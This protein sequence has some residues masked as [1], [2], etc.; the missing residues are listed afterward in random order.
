M[1]VFLRIPDGNPFPIEV[2]ND[3]TVGNLH[4][5]ASVELGQDINLS[6]DRQELDENDDTKLADVG[7]GAEAHLDVQFVLMEDWERLSETFKPLLDDRVH[8]EWFQEC[9]TSPDRCT[10]EAICAEGSRWTK[11]G[12]IQC[13]EANE[14]VSIWPATVTMFLS[15]HLKLIRIPRTVTQMAF[16]FGRIKSVSFVGIAK[17]KDLKKLIL[18]H[19]EI[20]SVDFRGLE[21]S[22]LEDLNLNDN[23]IASFDNLHALKHSALTQLLLDENKITAFNLGVLQNS[24]LTYLSLNSNQISAVDLDL[25]DSLLE[26]LLLEHNQITSIDL[27]KLKK[28]QLRDLRLFDNRISGTMNFGDLGGSKLLSIELRRNQIKRISFVSTEL[29]PLTSVSANDNSIE[30]IDF[31]G[32]SNFPE[33]L[34]MEW[35][36]SNFGGDIRLENE[37]EMHKMGTLEGDGI[38]RNRK[39][40]F[41]KSQYRYTRP[42]PPSSNSNFIPS[43][44]ADSM[45]PESQN[46]RDHQWIGWVIGSA[47]LLIIVVVALIIKVLHS[48]FHRVKAQKDRVHGLENKES[49]GVL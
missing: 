44:S 1:T 2:S 10:N 20:T 48:R 12:F 16:S 49:D 36:F 5:E 22:S 11:R 39:C 26:N 24:K 38:S 29:S 28:S 46:Q 41:R 6:F 47:I 18:S 45:E 4:Q 15:G 13:N 23:Q 25:K 17:L 32:I 37:V 33:L 34:F 35:R 43:D 9:K 8:A 42:S 30:S 14:I 19:N 40:I 7:I 27:T 21:Q 31:G 3:A